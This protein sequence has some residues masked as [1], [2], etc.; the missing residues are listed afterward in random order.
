MG[1]GA[2]HDLNKIAGKTVLKP[3]GVETSS[4]NMIAQLP[5][6]Q[7]HPAKKLRRSDHE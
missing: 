7:V 6:R 4:Q 2:T 3:R 1:G 5:V